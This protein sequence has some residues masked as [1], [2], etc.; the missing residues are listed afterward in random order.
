MHAT[1]VI[2]APWAIMPEKLLEIQAF[3]AAHVRGEKIDIAAI[4]AR[5]GK[6]LV[7]A[8]Q[9]YQ[10]VGG[11][12]VIPVNGVI[13]KKMNMMSQISGGAS[14]QLIERDI[15]AALSDSEV[16]SILLH[17]DSPGGTVDGTQTLANVVTM[18]KSI[19]PTMA[20]ADG[21][22]ASA[23]YW[24]GSAADEIVAAEGV[25]QIGSIGVVTSHTDMSKAQEQAGI[26]KTDIVAGKFK[27]IASQNSPL[28]D[29]ALA[30][31]QAEVDQ[32]YSMFVSAVAD[33]RGVSTE[34]VLED[35]ADGRVFLAEDAMD[36]GM[37]DH[38]ATLE[39]TILNMQTGVWP[40][41]SKKAETQAEPM[42]TQTQEV[43]TLDI[44][45]IKEQYPSIVA[46]IMQE[47]AEAERARIASCEASSLIGFEAIVNAMKLDGKST[48]ADVAVAIITEQKKQQ[49]SHAKAFVDNAPA[50]LEPAAVSGFEAAA[51]EDKSLPIDERAKAKWD[52]DANVRGEFGKFETFL[53]FFK[54]SESGRVRVSGKATH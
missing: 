43:I 46:E 18:A 52:S 33:N 17:I 5:L 41:A 14:T 10:N 7:S 51:E 30:Y 27:R 15:K 20:F 22:M 8:D 40:M 13:G 29:E 38:I 45:S 48:G 9:G 49:A 31:R 21:L 34:T 53:G 11:V 19:K 24:I 16:S 42:A 28:S 6:P 4:E 37:I 3:Y 50:V 12:A 32:I 44:Q 39:T 54:A 2:T 1:D 35:M 23:A 47:G 36:R 25:T 26:K